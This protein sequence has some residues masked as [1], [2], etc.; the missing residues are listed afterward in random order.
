MKPTTK[1]VD[2]MSLL[3]IN[4]CSFFYKITKQ[5]CGYKF[6]IHNLTNFAFYLP[7]LISGQEKDE[8]RYIYQ[9]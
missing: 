8:V 7:S 3:M 1:K 2:N 6:N 4:V 5:V 9:L